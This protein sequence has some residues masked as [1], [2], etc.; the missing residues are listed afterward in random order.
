MHALLALFR[1]WA[2]RAALLLA[3]IIAIAWL[4]LGMAWADDPVDALIVTGIDVS[5]SMEPASITV[6]IQ[7]IALAIQSP[8][9]LAAI[10]AGPRGRIGF[11][12]YLWADGDMPLVIGWRV[13]A[14]AEDAAAVAAELLAS[15]PS[16]IASGG[17][18]RFGTLTNIA[19][20][21]DRAV[22]LLQAAPMPAGRAVV[23]LVGDG[24]KTSGDD[25]ARA[26]AALLAAGATVNG[27]IVAGSQ[28]TVD[29]FRQ[30]VVGGRSAFVLT[31]SKAENLVYAFRRKFM[32]DL[33]MTD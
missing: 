30:Y 10:Q 12:V 25:P 16:L 6:E 15:L 9:V 18:S 21:L 5:G 4:I 20:A 24:A 17:T 14:T 8:D 22:A 7:G 28:E 29:Y 26:R 27:M 32:L 33:A 19:A 11:A 23:N 31:A 13:V 2:I 3:G 1:R